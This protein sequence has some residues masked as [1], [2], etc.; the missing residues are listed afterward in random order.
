[1][2]TF[3]QDNRV[4]KIETPLGKDVLILTGFSGTEAI[5]SLFRYELEMVSDKNDIKFED[6]I[7][8]GVTVS[9]MLHNG[10]WRY[11]NGIISS[12]RQTRGAGGAD[13][14]LQLAQYRAIMVPSFWILSR[15]TDSRIFQNMKPLEIIDKILT[16]KKVTNYRI[17]KKEPYYINREYCV[18]YNETDLNFISRLMEHEGIFYF[19]EHENGKHTMVI[20]DSAMAHKPCPGQEKAQCQISSGSLREKDYITGLERTVDIRPDKYSMADF[21]F[22]MPSTDLKIENDTKI[23]IGPPGRELYDYPGYYENRKDGDT[24]ANIRMQEEEAMITIIS[25]SSR[26]RAFASGYRFELEDHYREDMNKKEYI[27]TAIRHE[28]KEDVG[29]G[30]ETVDAKYENLFSCIPHEGTYRPQRK[31]P[32]PRIYGTQTAIV[33]GPKGEEIYTDEHGRVKVQFHWDR[34]GK[35]DEKSSCWIRVGQAWSGQGW[36]A[37]WI[38]R[39]GHEVIVDFLEGDPDRPII[40]GSVYNAHQTP[41]YALPPNATQSGIKSRSS[42]GGS[43]ANYNEIRFEDKKGSEQIQVHAEKNMDTTVEA[44]KTLEVGG[45]RKTHVKGSFTENIDSGET[46]QVDSGAKET[47]NGGMTQIIN[48]GEKRTISG[49]VT[50]TINGGEKRAITGNQDESIT[51]TETRMVTGAQNETVMGAVTQTVLGGMTINSPSGVTINAPAGMTINAPAGYTVIAP[52]GNKTVDSWFTKIGGK[53]EDLFAVQTAILS[54]QTTIAGM[55][56]AMQAAKIDV[57]G[58]ALERCGVK[59]ANEPLTFKQASTKLKSGAIGLYMY[60]LTLID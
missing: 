14:N 45:N 56:T 17:D 59:S 18:Q 20:A 52:G 60:T 51:G 5:S 24:I 28:A 32:K 38:P 6:I 47:I 7:G 41:P 40:T 23:P 21:N 19:F 30:G 3:T 2:P 39:I 53:D 4:M 34:E 35:R 11:F 43:D 48:A 37:I 15:T 58:I 46:R 16:E 22:K 55:S 12:F 36:G 57:T 31:T 42:K 25:G 49:G 1:M 54:M 50:E 27:I 29:A 33:A 9:S 26:C 13:K 10:D 44:D 8:K